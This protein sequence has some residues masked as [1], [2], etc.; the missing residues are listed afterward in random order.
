MKENTVPLGMKCDCSEAMQSMPTSDELE[1]D[2]K[3]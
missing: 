2:C 1:A 3:L